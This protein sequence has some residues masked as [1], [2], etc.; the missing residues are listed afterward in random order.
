MK[1][2][3]VSF[4]F[5]FALLTLPAWAVNSELQDA[6]TSIFHTNIV[7]DV[8]DTEAKCMRPVKKKGKVSYVPD[9]KSAVQDK[10]GNVI[11]RLCTHEFENCKVEGSCLVESETGKKLINVTGSGASTF[12]VIDQN[13]CKFGTGSIINKSRSCLIPYKTLACASHV[14][15]GTV[16]YIQEAVGKHYSVDGGPVETHDGNFICG[17][18]GKKIAGGDCRVDVF[19]GYR[20]KDQAYN[21]LDLVLRDEKV[22]NHCAKVVGGKLASDD[23]LI[24]DLTNLL[25]TSGASPAPGAVAENSAGR[26]PASGGGAGA[27]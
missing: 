7:K 20:G 23:K 25:L 4:L 13:K 3:S 16:I 9:T 22:V 5:L 15:V 19:T 11:A 21:E 6:S 26:S 1:L 10:K 24:K 2:S 8:N 27:R 17:D 12:D 14:P 18:R